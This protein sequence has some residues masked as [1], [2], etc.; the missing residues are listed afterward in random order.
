[1]AA[2]ESFPRRVALDL[3][4]FKTVILGKYFVEPIVLGR[5]PWAVVAYFG[6][7]FT[8]CNVK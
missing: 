5:K 7:N 2:A 4:A 6:E 8:I 1:M 3:G